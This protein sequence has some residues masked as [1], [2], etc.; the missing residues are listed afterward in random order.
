MIA[1]YDACIR[2]NADAAHGRCLAPGEQGASA[3]YATPSAALLKNAT[4]TIELSTY[5]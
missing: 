1:D 3:P 2:A 4:V 5:K